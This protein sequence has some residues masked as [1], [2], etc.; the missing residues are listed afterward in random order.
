MAHIGG[1]DS[2]MGRGQ[3]GDERRIAYILPAAYRRM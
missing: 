1:L 3:A 2:G